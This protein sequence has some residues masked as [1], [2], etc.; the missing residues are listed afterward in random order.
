MLRNAKAR[1]HLAAVLKAFPSVRR[2]W[3]GAWFVLLVWPAPVGPLPVSAQ[4]RDARPT[5]RSVVDV[6]SVAVVV[7]DRAG[8]P[9]RGLSAADFTVLDGGIERR[10]VDFAPGVPGAVSLALLVDESGSMRVGSSQTLA[11]AVASELVE[12]LEASGR[13][14]DEVAVYA[15]DSTVRERVPFTTDLARARA[16]LAAWEPFGATSLYDA[17]AAVAGELAPRG[18][19]NRALV[20]VTDGVDNRSR[21]RLE[22]A[23]GL[24]SAIDVPV[25]VVE[26]GTSAGAAATGS[27][28]RA[29]RL[30]A[31]L[32]DLARWTGGERHLVTSRPGEA[33]RVVARI[34][35]DVRLQ[36]LLAFE[37]A[38]F[39]G[40]RPLEIRARRP[41]LVVRARGAYLAGGRVAA[42]P[43]RDP[44]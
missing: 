19:A 44:S 42:P 36:Y 15:F 35:S 4:P 32:E 30:H 6:V 3:L 23:S 7:R 29:P 34:V 9:V 38:P 43:A 17:I 5:F 33:R 25:Y 37:S 16:G 28:A 22:E 24:A 18:R 2:T 20:V 13:G 31:T 26:V 41:G 10:I 14:L 12:A 27:D 40:W 21:L 39:P 11:R 1:G 8:R